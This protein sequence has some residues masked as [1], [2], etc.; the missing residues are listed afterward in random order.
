VALRLLASVAGIGGRN[1]ADP[2]IFQQTDFEFKH[3]V[4]AFKIAYGMEKI[5][6]IKVLTALETRF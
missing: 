6:E 3:P 1:D 5:A 2:D 4:V